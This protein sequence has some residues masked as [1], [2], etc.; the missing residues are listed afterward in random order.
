MDALS[1]LLS[2]GCCYPVVQTVHHVLREGL[3]VCVP[4]IGQCVRQLV[5]SKVVPFLM[6]MLFEEVGFPV[7]KNLGEISKCLADNHC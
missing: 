2:D 4:H 3:A 6:P 1:S 7:L 5:L